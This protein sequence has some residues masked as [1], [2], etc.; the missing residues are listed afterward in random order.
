AGIL[1]GGGGAEDVLARLMAPKD[2]ALPAPM[3]AIE[4]K[5][6]VSR[7]GSDA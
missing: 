1:P 2:E 5:A 6:K 7:D 3:L 4:D